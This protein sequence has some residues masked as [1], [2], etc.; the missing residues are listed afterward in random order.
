MIMSPPKV[1]ICGDIVWAHEE[2]AEMLGSIANVV[3][4]DSHSRD[5]FV[6]ELNGGKYS[7]IVGIYRHNSSAE[8]IGIFDEALISQLPSTLEWIAH[9]G[10]GYDQIDISACKRRGIK[11]SNTPGAVDDG[12]ATTAMYLLIS[13]I[14]QFSIAERHART[15][16][17]KSGLKPAHD[18]SAMTLGILGL[19]GIGLHFAK[20]A[21]VFPMKKIFYHSRNKVA[22]APEWV[23]YCPT[24]EDLLKKS[25]VVSLHVPLKQETEHLIGDRE[26]GMMK[27]GS[28]L[29]NTARGKVVDEAALIRALRNG[30]LYAAGLDVYPDEPNINPELLE[31]NNVTL[32]P[33]MGTETQESQKSMEIRAM[34]N[35]RTYLTGGEPGDLIPE[36]R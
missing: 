13:T 18:P 22:H 29:I 31:F 24:M 14:R 7:G 4:M 6:K 2:C 1:L 23:E 28:I 33:H 5:E 9:N 36:Y 15:G 19:G 16:K 25:D 26:L 34:E 3:R 20:L 32:L 35:L 10:A 8:R 11:V 30:H 27:K 12:T 17:W 21:N